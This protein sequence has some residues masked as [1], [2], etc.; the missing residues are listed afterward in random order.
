MAK[1]RTKDEIRQTRVDMVN[2]VATRLAN[3][4][5]TTYRVLAEMVGMSAGSAIQRHVKADDNPLQASAEQA[6]ITIIKPVERCPR[7]TG[8]VADWLQN[9]KPCLDLGHAMANGQ[10]H[11]SSLQTD[12][13]AEVEDEAEQEKAG[14]QDTVGGEQAPP[15]SNA[16]APVGNDP[17]WYDPDETLDHQRLMY[18]GYE[19]ARAL[20]I[21]RASERCL[22]RSGFKLQQDQGI[23]DLAFEDVP[24]SETEEN[25]LDSGTRMEH[26]MLRSLVKRGY[27]VNGHWR[28]QGQHMVYHEID[29]NTLLVGH[30]DGYLRAPGDDDWMIFDMKTTTRDRFEQMRHDFDAVSG[31]DEQVNSIVRD[32]FQQLRRYLAMAIDL[33]FETSQYLGVPDMIHPDRA[34]VV[35][36][37]RETGEMLVGDFRIFPNFDSDGTELHRQY[38]EMQTEVVQQIEPPKPSDYFAD[39]VMCARCA[40]HEMCYPRGEE[41]QLTKDEDTTARDAEIW[42]LRQ[43][44]HEM[45]VTG[46]ALET[47]A[48]ER[49]ILAAKEAGAR[50]YQMTPDVSITVVEQ[51]KRS[52]IN[53]GLMEE[54][55]TV[56]RY[57]YR[58]D[59]QDVSVRWYPKKE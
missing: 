41:G 16:T 56:D 27:E 53:K 31:T 32:Y 52:R 54:D 42:E 55:G 48:K 38:L 49:A 7:C 10:Q 15:V 21:V 30:P 22:R 14:L 58:P 18:C 45:T 3:G 13:E 1:R 50:R 28:D 5:T 35:L 59:G 47:E 2:I 33:P 8:T 9:D 6:G 11:G 43:R 23:L 40:F 12:Q 51:K 17:W 34:A 19:Y 46:K 39:S 29:R 37:C 44:G 26:I 4:L 20:T 25:L 24:T 36:Y 57:E